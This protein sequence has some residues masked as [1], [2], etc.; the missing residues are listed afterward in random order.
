[1]KKKIKIAFIDFWSSFYAG[2]INCNLYSAVLDILSERYEV[3]LSE[4]P[5][6]IFYSCFGHENLS[7]DCIKIFFTGELLTPNF[8]ECDYAIGFDFMDYGDRYL[9]FPLYRL[10]ERFSLALDKHIGIEGALKGKSGFCSFVVSNGAGQKARLEMFEKLSSYKK[11]DS[12]GKFMNNV[13]GAVRDKLAFDSSHKFSIAFENCCYNG[14]VTEKI[15]DAFAAKTVPIYC[16]SRSIADEFNP[17][18]F[19]DCT[20]CDSVDEM[21][22]LV[23]RVDSDD[24]LYK[25]MLSTPIMKD[26]TSL[27]NDELRRFL[28]HIFDQDYDQA[29]RIAKDSPHIQQEVSFKKYLFQCREFVINYEKMPVRSRLKRDVIDLFKRKKNGLGGNDE[30]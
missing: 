7:Y 1:M 15:V 25:K 18:S 11:V 14:Y 4:Q 30:L 6:Y 3:E 17:D 9:R 21:V 29:F 10:S 13:G 19:I 26:K 23:K 16:G 2:D 20:H 28:F 8:N 22:E 27:Q 24:E 12:G 5:D